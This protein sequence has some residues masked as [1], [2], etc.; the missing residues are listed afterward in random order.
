M[1]GHPI[2]RFFAGLILTAFTSFVP[3][4]GLC[5]QVQPETG[6]AYSSDRGQFD[7]ARLLFDGGEYDAAAREFARVIEAF[8]ASPLKMDSQLM[9]AEAY[10]RSGL[11]T[12]ARDELG[13]FLSNYPDSAHAARASAMVLEADRRLF[14]ISRPQAEP[15]MPD[16]NRARRLRAVQVM[17]FEGKTIGEVRLELG[18]LQAAGMDTV[19]VRVFHNSGDR[20]YPMSGRGSKS[21]VYFKTSAAPVVDDLLGGVVEAAHSS[22][23]KVFAWMT[24][25]YADYGVEND[26]D[27]ACKGYDLRSGGFGRCKGLDLFNERAVARLEAIYSDLAS[28]EIDGILFQD[29]LVLRHS[30]GFG[31]HMDALFMRDT[32]RS[33]SPSSLYIHTTSGAPEKVRYT[34]LFWQW[35][36]WK[37][38]RLLDVAGRLRDAVRKKRPETLFA[39]NL[40]YESVTNPQYALAWLSQDLKEAQ[41]K[42]FDYFSVMAYHIQ[43]GD[44]LGRGSVEIASMI[45]DMAEGLAKTVGEPHRVLIKLQTIDWKTGRPL[46]D[47]EVVSL[48]REIRARA[49]V[50]LAV[51][52]YRSGFPFAEITGTDGLAYLH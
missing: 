6:K 51:V 29:D 8:P 15:A 46:S 42:G 32:G 40:M 16:F 33:A 31:P 13:L 14:D 41:R 37:N 28:Y 1:A 50:S 11:L 17:N 39:L 7:Y 23:L 45:G 35:A 3:A 22:G 34:G 4:A 24:T 18:R 44:E 12:E 47:G 27:L 52:P 9:L 21:G 38:R 30:E 26:S 43:M 49:D 48:A 5:S 36:S 2:K 10:L 20:Y 25:R 19:I